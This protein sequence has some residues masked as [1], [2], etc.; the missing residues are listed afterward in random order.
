MVVA[1]TMPNLSF[2]PGGTP[3]RRRGWWAI[4]LAVLGVG[5]AMLVSPLRSPPLYDGIGFPDEPYRW[6]QAPPGS[7]KTP[8]VTPATAKVRVGVDGVVP[9]LKGLSAEQGAQI[10]FQIEGDSLVLPKGGTTLSAS[11]LAGRN[12]TTAP[13]DGTLVS[14]VYTLAVTA[15]VPGE[16]TLA[17]GKTAIINM[18]SSKTTNDTIV[19]EKLEAGTWSQVA[20]GRVGS[21]IYAAELD[22]LGQFA[23]VQLKP[24]RKPTVSPT[25][26]GLGN[27]NSF[28][29]QNSAQ[30][31]QGASSGGGA[32]VYL[33]G[34]GMVLLLL[35]G[36]F[37][38]RRRMG[39]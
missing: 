33:A 19:L 13:P 11:A 39:G 1:L 14:N 31:Q 9:V 22:S 12:P 36:L 27:N 18:R 17:P 23:L 20:T 30:Q 29:T 32:T 6:V 8:P 38:A 25:G 7:P 37:I 15:D 16:P 35:L 5:A 4:L 10:A 26:P 2:D 3:H 28:Q 24:G 21:D 34:G